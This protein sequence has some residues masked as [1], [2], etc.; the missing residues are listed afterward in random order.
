MFNFLPHC[1]VYKP[2]FCAITG[3]YLQLIK[4]PKGVWRIMEKTAGKYVSRSQYIEQQWL[5]CT[6][7]AFVWFVRIDRVW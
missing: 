1:D 7:W 2:F 6:L 5:M 3:H 4:A